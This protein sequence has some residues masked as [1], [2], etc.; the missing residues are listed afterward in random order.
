M[1]SN[2]IQINDEVIKGIIGYI[3]PIVLA[4]I[5]SFVGPLADFAWSEVLYTWRGPVILAALILGYLIAPSFCGWIALTVFIIFLL[6]RIA[7][8]LY[9]PKLK[10]EFAPIVFAGFY[11][12]NKNGKLK[13]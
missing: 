3:V 7:R 11:Q 2:G 4:A 10:K 1:D 13:R 5:V 9:G 6:L 8:Y 12:T